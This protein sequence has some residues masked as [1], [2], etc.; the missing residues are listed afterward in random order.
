MLTQ[1][2][3]AYDPNSRRRSACWLRSGNTRRAS[4]PDSR[5]S[6]GDELSNDLPAMELVEPQVDVIQAQ[7]SA[8]Q[9]IDRKATGLVQIDIAGDVTH[10]YTA[11]D[12]A[13]FECALLAYEAHDAQGQILPRR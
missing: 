7:A 6:E 11:P 3:A 9:A 13:T 2:I 4:A 1:G 5:S 8:H 10:G 12:I